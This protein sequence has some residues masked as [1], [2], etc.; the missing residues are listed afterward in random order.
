MIDTEKI[1]TIIG[2]GGKTIRAISESTGATVN[3]EP[4]GQVMVYSIDKASADAAIAQIKGLIEEPEKGKIYHGVVKK[5]ME[6]GAFIEFMPNR[7]GLCHI[8]KLSH[9]RVNRVEDVLKEGQEVNVK[10]ID[11]DRSGRYSLSMVDAQN[12][13]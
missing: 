6:F 12:P 4:N 9:E 11:I 8:S 1:G 7:D 10:L 2:P 13:A 3:V 5:I